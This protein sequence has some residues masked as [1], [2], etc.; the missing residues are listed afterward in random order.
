[1]N[2]RERTFVIPRETPL[3]LSVEQT[4]SAGETYAAHLAAAL[5]VKTT[6]LSWLFIEAEGRVALSRE[7]TEEAREAGEPNWNCY[8]DDIEVLETALKD[9]RRMLEQVSKL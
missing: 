5:R 9:A 2:E 4:D 3:S 7:W 6:E 1:M 8:L